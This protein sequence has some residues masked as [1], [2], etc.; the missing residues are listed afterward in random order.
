ML[1]NIGLLS[2]RVNGEKPFRFAGSGR[3]V[4]QSVEIDQFFQVV[5]DEEDG[6][7]TEHAE[8]DDVVGRQTWSTVQQT[9]RQTAQSTS[10][11]D[12]VLSAA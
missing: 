2:D 12:T 8:C 3:R 10:G 1:W 5:G 4:D 9:A 6:Q 7:T 11:T